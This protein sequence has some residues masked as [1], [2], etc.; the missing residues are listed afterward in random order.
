VPISEP[1]TLA[2]D[3]LLAALAVGLGARLLRTEGRG[4]RLATGLWGAAFLA[5]AAAA[6]AGGAVHGFAASLSPVAHAALWKTV[7]VGCGLAG[8]LVLAGTVLATLRGRWRQALLAGAAGQLAGYVVLVSRR[9][10]V[11][12]AVWN[13]AAT[14]LAVLALRDVRRLGW[15]LLALGLSAAGL[16]AQ[17]AHASA[18]A[19]NHNDVC[20]VLQIASLWPFYRAALRLHRRDRPEAPH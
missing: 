9:D 1:T 2:S 13:G 11:A 16:A 17:R 5:V 15:V 18:T 10:D 20:H 14:I 19:L 6:V 12:V 7:L 4:G 8:G 3:W